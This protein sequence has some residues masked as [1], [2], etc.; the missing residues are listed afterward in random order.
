M[1]LSTKREKENLQNFKEI[2]RDL[3]TLLRTSLQSETVSMHWVNNHRKMLILENYTTSR[4]NVVFQDRMNY[5]DHFLGNYTH[6]K[7]VTRLE[8]GNHVAAEELTHYMSAPSVR[9]IYLIP[10]VFNSETVAVTSV[11]AF[12]KSS[13]TEIDQE[14]ISAYQKIMTRLLQTYLELSDITEKQAE[15][16]EYDEI[17]GELALSRNTLELA[18]NLLDELQG[19]VVGGGVLL[20]ARGMNDWH[21]VIYSDK[22]SNPPPVGLPVQE[23]SIADQALK[24]GESF[25]CTHFN[26]NPKRISGHEPICNGA[27]L[28]VP[29]LHQQRRQMLVLVYTEN[30]LIFSEAVKHKIANLGRIA[31]LKFES[32]MPDLDV[33]EDIFSTALTTYS[34]DLFSKSLA[35]I[36]KHLNEQPVALSTWVGMIT[37]GNI[38][39]LRTKYRLEDLT[40]LQRQVLQ[41]LAPQEFGY[42]GIISRYSDYIYQFILQSTDEAAFSQWAE[43]LAR[44]F[45]EPVS[46]TS[47]DK[48]IIQLN[49]GY[50]LLHQGGDGDMAM[51]KT[52][53]AMNEA[54]KTGTFI[55]ES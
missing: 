21:T 5:D 50:K 33:Q 6:I 47:D 11:E 28:A 20:I 30:P 35:V 17:T 53:S 45:R 55:V 37:I 19:L 41:K 26:A 10:F 29:I 13:I 15:W 48:E 43:G 51:Q 24:N 31:G 18:I 8:I 4:K 39:S 16:I 12:E 52:K 49:I 7:S 32:L 27:T 54:V 40:Q 23:G 1:T 25:F 22:A 3:I 38:S 42:S 34:E 9:Y 44:E 46:F 36:Q 2:I 14:S